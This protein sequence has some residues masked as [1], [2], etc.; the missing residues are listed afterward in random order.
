MSLALLLVLYLS[1]LV[2]KGVRVRIMTN[3]LAANDVAV[4][5]WS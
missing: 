4:V 5:Y 3:S 2:E 1:G